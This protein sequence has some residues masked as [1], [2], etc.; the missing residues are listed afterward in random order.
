G[1]MRGQGRV[2]THRWAEAIATCREAQKA[3][4]HHTAI[5]LALARGLEAQD[6]F[7]G[8]EAVY[9]ETI[10]LAPRDVQPRLALAELQTR[11]GDVKRAASTYTVLLDE[12]DPKNLQAH[13]ELIRIMLASG[14]SERAA[15]QLK[16]MKRFGQDAP[17]VVRCEARVK[18]LTAKTPQSQRLTR[19]RQ[20]LERLNEQ[21]P[22][23]VRTMYDVAEAQ[24]GAGDYET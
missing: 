22:G 1:A 4:F 6:D 18:L 23:D 9:R 16:D 7:D 8:A 3:G 11:R 2:R 13:E 15:A 21:Q 10:R 24:A 19:Y 20:A 14:Q 12:A 5:Q 17:A